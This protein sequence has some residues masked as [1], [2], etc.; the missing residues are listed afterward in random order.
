MQLIRVTKY[1]SYIGSLASI[2]KHIVNSG[3]DAY[4]C[5][6]EFGRYTLYRSLDLKRDIIQK[7]YDKITSET[8]G[9]LSKV[10]AKIIFL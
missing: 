10:R 2:H 6:N 7:N 1:F 8:F 5:V 4:I 9:A 3:C